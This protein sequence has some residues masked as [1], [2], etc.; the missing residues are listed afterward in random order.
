MLKLFS[1][2]HSRVKESWNALVIKINNMSFSTF[3]KTMQPYI[4]EVTKMDGDC[5]DEKTYEFFLKKVIHC[6]PYN[7]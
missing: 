4:D 5:D 6:L 7:S 3:Q 1:S 2:D